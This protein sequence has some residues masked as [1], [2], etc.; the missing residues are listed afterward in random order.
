MRSILIITTI[1]SFCFFCACTEDIVSKDQKETTQNTPT[2]NPEKEKATVSTTPSND[3]HLD[4]PNEIPA[5]FHENNIP[6]LPNTAIE[7]VR[8]LDNENIKQYVVYQLSDESIESLVE[9]Y[10]TKLV[11]SGWKFRGDQKGYSGERT[12]LAFVKDQ[13]TFNAILYQNNDKVQISSVLMV[14]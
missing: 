5:A 14:R 8:M 13:K 7:K 6:E 2:A 10:K 9:T 3:P 4:L 11:K 1:F 12:N